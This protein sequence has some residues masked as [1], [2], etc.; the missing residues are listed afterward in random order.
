MET[1]F[2]KNIVNT[3]LFNK[4]PSI[5]TDGI[6]SVDNKQE[7]IIKF[8]NNNY[9][10]EYEFILNIDN[11]NNEDLNEDEEKD[12]NNYISMINEEYK[13]LTTIIKYIIANIDIEKVIIPD[14]KI[15]DYSNIPKNL[16]SKIKSHNHIFDAKKFIMKN[17]IDKTIINTIISKM[18]NKELKETN[19]LKIIAFFIITKIMD[20]FDKYNKCLLYS[21]ELL[22][23]YPYIFRYKDDYLIT[24]NESY[25]TINDNNITINHHNIIKNTFIKNNNDNKKSTLINIGKNKNNNYEINFK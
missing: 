12:K 8:E 25:F 5:N 22:K 15:Y 7:Q 24:I 17:N 6:F 18:K 4:L 14:Y 3:E 16:K 20:I 1:L 2:I 13:K 11:I 21:L 9:N 10:D 23:E 19:E